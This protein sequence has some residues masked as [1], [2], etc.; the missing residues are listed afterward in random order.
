MILLYKYNINGKSEHWLAKSRKKKAKNS[1]M[2]DKRLI[3]IVIG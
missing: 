2:L 3:G 1:T